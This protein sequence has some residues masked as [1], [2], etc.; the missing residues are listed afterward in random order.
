MTEAALHSPPTDCNQSPTKDQPSS[1]TELSLHIPH[2]KAIQP[3]CPQSKPLLS[4]SSPT[5]SRLMHQKKLSSHHQRSH[6]DGDT[7][8]QHK[9]PRWIT[10]DSELERSTNSTTPYVLTV[11]IPHQTVSGR[12]RKERR[13]VCRD[14]RTASTQTRDVGPH[15]C[16]AQGK[17][18]RLEQR[19]QIVLK[20]VYVHVG[21]LNIINCNVGDMHNELS[22]N[23]SIVLMAA[24]VWLL[25]EMQGMLNLLY[26]P[27]SRL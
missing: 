27:L 18:K 21:V 7:L 19:L 3:S 8:S 13:G 11:T 22:Y 23:S 12:T 25:Y 16:A 15:K 5:R 26:I 1:K 10:K 4:T 9:K 24:C 6:S 2:S 14:V 20:K 17:V